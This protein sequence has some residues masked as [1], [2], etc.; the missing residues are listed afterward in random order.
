[1]NSKAKIYLGLPA[2][3]SETYDKYM[4][5]QPGE[6]GQILQHFQC[7]YPELFGGV[8]VYEATASETNAIDGT[9][10]ADAVKGYL[11]DSSC[12]TKP[13]S[14]STKSV[15]TFPV[16]SVASM[17]NPSSTIVS[18]QS[19]GILSANSSS[20][21][22]VVPS[23]AYVSIASY[24][25]STSTVSSV[26]STTSL[27]S[28]IVSTQSIAIFSASSSSGR[29]AVPSSMHV[30]MASYN[31]STS[32]VSFVASPTSSSS[33]IVST[34]STA[35]FSANSSSDRTAVPSSTHLSPASFNSSSSHTGTASISLT[36]VTRPTGGPSNKLPDAPSNYNSTA[37]QGPTVSR[38]KMTGISSYF[39]QKPASTSTGYNISSISTSMTTPIATSSIFTS[40]ISSYSPSSQNTASTST[41]YKISSISTSNSTPNATSNIFKGSISSYSPSSGVPSKLNNHSS[42][43]VYQYPSIRTSVVSGIPSVG[44]YQSSIHTSFISDTVST[45]L[46]SRTTDSASTRSPISSFSSKAEVVRSSVVPSVSYATMTEETFTT[47]M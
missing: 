22:T 25:S 6:A 47:K 17:T 14:T 40:S 13:S 18:T 3:P 5:L 2:S 44:S 39:S 12:A 1:M 15:P 30:S 32:P 41:G 23:S 42:T 11:K 34:Q 19:V 33:A 26:A 31:S 37:N 29:T 46:N 24:N 8:M 4:Y 20:R 45:T 36:Y 21:K 43:L 28:A 10:Y 35:I 9:P 16:S 7:K 27:S 38:S